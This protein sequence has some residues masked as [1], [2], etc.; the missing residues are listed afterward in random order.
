[1]A[2]TA[3]GV[4]SGIDIEGILQQLGE[5]ERQPVEVLN[6][7]KEALDVELSA[8]G[9]VK[10]ALSGF[11]TAAKNLGSDSDFGGFVAT[12]SD[13]DVF[14]ATAVDGEAAVNHEVEVLALA[15][16]HRLA[17]GPYASADSAVGAGTL[18]FSSGD[19][20]FD[21]VVD[22][23]N[24][25][26][27]GL[28]DAINANPLNSSVSASIINVDG[29]SRLVLTATES[30]R[31][32]MIDV[33]RNSALP[34]GDNSA[35]FTEISEATDASLIVH[36]F[37]VTR[38]SNT[39]NDVISGVTLDLTGVGK[40]TVDSRRDLTSLKAAADEF[41]ASYNSMSSALEN[42]AQTDLNGDQLPR[43]IDQRVRS[44]FFN[45]V[46]LGGG[47]SA[48]ALDLGFSFDRFGKLTLDSN[49][50]EQALDAGVNRY[51]EAFAKPE[52]GLASI[53]S[54]LIDEYTKS[55]GIISGREDGVDTRKSSID[56]QIERLE[57]RLEKTNER[58]RRQFTAMDLAVTNLQQTSG[59]LT[60]RLG[61]TNF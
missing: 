34:L 41:V 38:S 58:L 40:S 5:I 8:F 55:D 31:D 42:I 50:Y 48:T 43:G 13:E 54:D 39:I 30:G 33:S 51:V 61:I 47:D 21:V 15:T 14:T 20:S 11:Q 57:Y 29:G 45:S 59:F 10:S 17:S 24:N 60:S 49:R 1:M 18:T 9:Q 27:G 22:D 32:G 2:L 35:G 12:S 4:G 6:R 37:Q 3:A 26:L 23:T 19:N 52:T 7:R 36:G 44:M 53:F 16:N 28:K 46:D 56:S 25:S